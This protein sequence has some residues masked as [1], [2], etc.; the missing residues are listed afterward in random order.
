MGVN[1]DAVSR[2]GKLY[3]GRFPSSP[4]SRSQKINYFNRLLDARGL[5]PVTTLLHAESASALREWFPGNTAALIQA[6][7]DTEA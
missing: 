7:A 1:P 6:D 5:L 4:S 2:L 3:G